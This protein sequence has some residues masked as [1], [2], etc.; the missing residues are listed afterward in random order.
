MAT[1]F[2]ELIIKISADVNDMRAGMKEAQE[3]TKN[4]NKSI[5]KSLANMAKSFLRLGAV[6]MAT[7]R[8]I[9]EFRQAINMAD[10]LAKQS[11]AL[12]ISTQ[13]L[14][15]FQ[16]AADLAGVNAQQF[17]IGIEAMTRNLGLAA[18]GTGEAKEAL[19]S[20][21]LSVN[22]LLRMTPD[23]QFAA[24][25][26]ALKGVG[27]QTERVAIATRIFGESG[28]RLIPLM[29]GG[30]KAFDEAEEATKRY[31]LALDRMDFKRIEQVKD[32]ITRMKAAWAGFL[33]NLLANW[34]PELYAFF[35]TLQD[36]GFHL[37][38]IW[39][40]LQGI[41]WRVTEVILA[42]VKPIGTAFSHLFNEVLLPSIRRF[43]LLYD[44][45]AIKLGKE[46]IGYIRPINIK[47]IEESQKK[48]L[49]A[50]RNAS[51][52]AFFDAPT[53]NDDGQAW[54]WGR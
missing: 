17:R 43:A 31:G 24:I 25:A 16:H 42:S 47:R 1:T 40:K 28:T 19:K 29:Q 5:G 34:A 10:R 12:G 2:E 46:P 38:I 45:I 54:I 3:A 6:I 53:A 49:F 41:W 7:R 50:I 15:A 44:E 14:V 8:V 51:S 30:K 4:A 13:K 52:Q 37:S 32:S 23:Q 48:A 11:D 36:M 9:N 21:S 18:L 39:K 35:D 26:E 33:R 20:M 27:T 22:D